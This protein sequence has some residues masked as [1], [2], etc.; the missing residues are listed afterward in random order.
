MSGTRKDQDGPGTGKAP[1][2]QIDHRTVSAVC[3]WMR[4]RALEYGNAD[5]AA[6]L[7][8]VA[9]ELASEAPEALVTAYRDALGGRAT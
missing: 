4:D 8:S 9:D 1:D 7:E 6:L 2:V 5:D 3:A